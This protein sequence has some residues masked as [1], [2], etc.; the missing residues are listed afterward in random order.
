MQII[1]P[2]DVMIVLASV[3]FANVVFSSNKSLFEWW[4]AALNVF[5]DL[6]T[7]VHCL[8]VCRVHGTRS[9]LSVEWCVLSLASTERL[10][11]PTLIG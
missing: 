1:H 9:H 5:S 6:F 2:S 4:F 3:I 11:T 7:F 8:P 10:A